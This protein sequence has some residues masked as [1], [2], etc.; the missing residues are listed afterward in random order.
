MIFPSSWVQAYTLSGGIRWQFHAANGGQRI[1]GIGA[2]D[3]ENLYF[4]G[5]D[6]FFYVL[7]KS[8]GRLKWSLKIGGILEGSPSLDDDSVYVAYHDSP[9]WGDGLARVNRKSGQVMWHSDVDGI[10]FFSSPFVDREDSRIYVGV[11][12]GSFFGFDKNTG[13]LVAKFQDAGKVDSL[14]NFKNSRFL[15]MNDAGLIY[16]LD[17]TNQKSFRFQDLR[18]LGELG[19]TLVRRS[20]GNGVV[21]VVG[22][23]GD[24]VGID[25]AGKRANWKF[26]FN[27]QS[28]GSLLVT[29]SASGNSTWLWAG[30]PKGLCALD[31]FTGKIVREYELKATFSD[32][33]IVFGRSIFVALDGQG[34]LERLQDGEHTSPKAPGH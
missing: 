17:L 21:V 7:R 20:D 13:S 29:K 26:P 10:Q 18:P 32:R 24:L 28:R 27:K 14:R 33:P 19:P 22:E 15:V 2:L 11:S 5:P 23:D 3:S 9:F 4:G 34:G 25:M 6:G 30:C 8:D 1:N 31:P 12:D 16:V